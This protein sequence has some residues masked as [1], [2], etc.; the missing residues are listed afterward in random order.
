MKETDYVV[1]Q[2]WMVSK[3][4]LKGNDLIVYAIIYGFSRNQNGQRFI[5][6]LQYLAD[7]TNSTKNGVA[8]NLRNLLDL[9]YIEKTEEIV[10]GVKHCYYEVTDLDAI[11]LCC[12]GVSNSVGQGIQQSCTNNINNNID[13]KNIANNINKG[14]SA[15]DRMISDL[16]A[17]EKLKEALTNFVAMRKTI[18]APITE[19]GMQMLLS[20]LFRIGAD[21]ATR[22]A[23]LEQSIMNGWKG[24]FELHNNARSNK[25]KAEQRERETADLL[26]D[27][28]NS[29]KGA[30]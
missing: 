22:I 20:K 11:Q 10:A 23:I 27:W 19:I 15:V 8:K 18:R 29:R 14:V 7:W 26:Q 2:N 28:M 3:L 5:G 13:K 24:I 30:E 6:S 21:D 12:M 25:T 17:S 9:G 16:D 1:I 4:R